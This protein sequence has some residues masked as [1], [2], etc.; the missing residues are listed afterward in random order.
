[1]ILHVFCDLVWEVFGQAF[2]DIWSGHAEST[3]AGGHHRRS[4]VVHFAVPGFRAFGAGFASEA[5][6]KA[7]SSDAAG[8]ALAARFFGEEGHGLAGGVHHVA[9]IVVD[10]DA[11]GAEE[12]IFAADGRIIKGDIKV[13]ASQV[14]A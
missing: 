2:G 5:F 3:S 7:F 10:N 13:V 9:R 6:D 11:A 4:Q 14:A 8:K 12:G 1:M